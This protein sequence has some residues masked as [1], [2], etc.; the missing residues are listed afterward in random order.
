VTFFASVPVV[1]TIWKNN[2]AGLPRIQRAGIPL[3]QGQAEGVR[4]V[5]PGE[6]KAQG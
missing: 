2:L 3:L 5:Q 1:Q 6:E 4:A